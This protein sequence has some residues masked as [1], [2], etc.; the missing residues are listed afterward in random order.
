MVEL[1]ARSAVRQEKYLT[2]TTEGWR[3]EG[4]SGVSRRSRSL[5]IPNNREQ[6]SRRGEWAWSRVQD[7]VGQR[8]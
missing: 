6:P 8:F 5:V 1:E 2:A 4:A 3:A 7:A